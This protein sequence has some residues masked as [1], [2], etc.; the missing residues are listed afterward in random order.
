MT[1]TTRVRLT[2]IGKDFTGATVLDGVDLEL[3][4]G[5]V[6]GLIGE[7]GAGKSTLLT[8]LSGVFPPS[9]GTV[10][11]DGAPVTVPDYRAANELG[12]FRVYQDLALVESLTVEENLLLGWERRFA[13]ALGTV[14]RRRRRVVA[15]RALERLGLPATLAGRRAADLSSSV[16]QSLSFAKVLATIDLLGTPNPVVFLDEP[17]TSLDKHGEER[18]LQ[19]VRE[20]ATDGAA[21]VFVSHLLEEILSVT[22][23]VLVL[24]DGRLV[25]ERP[26]EGL[27]EEDLH[28]LMVGRVRSEQYYREHLQR[29][30]EPGP[31]DTGVEVTGLRVDGTGPEV[32]LRIAP[33]E[34]VGLGGLEGSGKDE[35]G[36]QVAGAADSSHVLTFDG[37]PVRYGSVRDAVERGIVYLPRDRATSGVFADKSIRF[38]LVIGSL[39]DRYA[40]RLGVI[41]R[42][43]TRSAAS[44]LV[45]AYGVRTRGIEQPIGELSGGN[46]QKVLIARWL[47]RH[48]R[49]VVL[50]APTQGVDTGSRE[51]IYEAIRAA[52]AQGSAVLVISDDLL[53]LIGLSDRVLVVRDRAV[54]ADIPSPPGA[55][56]REDDVVPF[57]FRPS[58]LE[59]VS[60]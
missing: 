46:Q 17:T 7:N 15:T 39:H 11:V 4:S 27:L 12:L 3:R 19:V 16:Q 51:S 42:R 9:R 41:R 30:H 18:F 47:H 45:A 24:K 14:D 33:G 10:E 25:A 38:N 44:E 6:V 50:D 52:A 53:E 55:K 8:V 60:S 32:T 54:V 43:R 40:N 35:I 21:I 37:E 28:R 2:G 58:D 22:D 31:L 26:T 5:E 29:Q 34:V 56:P 49:L 20:L 13:R 23:R 57:M 1:A 36:A 48:P 59:T